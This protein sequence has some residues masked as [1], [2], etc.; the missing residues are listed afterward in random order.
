MKNILLAFAILFSSFLILFDA[1]AYVSVKG[2][3]RKDGTYVRPHVRSNPNG[4]KYDNYG[5]TPSQGLYNKTYG[6]RGSYWDTPTYITDPYYYKGKSLYESGAYR[7]SKNLIPSYAYPTVPTY[8]NTTNSLSVPR[9]YGVVRNFPIPRK[10]QYRTPFQRG[11]HSN[12]T[13]TCSVLQ[14][15]RLEMRINCYYFQ[16]WEKCEKYIND[17][18]FLCPGSTKE[19]TLL[20]RLENGRKC[21]TTVGSSGYGGSAHWEAQTCIPAE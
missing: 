18:S 12:K 3:F 9:S 14:T 6:T 17:L 19:K 16:D 11:Y 10:P 7:S 4:L 8:Y 20:R 15:K 21:N 5:W 13:K 1:D 2:Y